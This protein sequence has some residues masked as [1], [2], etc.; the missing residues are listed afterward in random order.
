MRIKHVGSSRLSATFIHASAACEEQRE[1]E[2][3]ACN[4]GIRMHQFSMP[5]IRV[6]NYRTKRPVSNCFIQLV[7][8]KWFFPYGGSRLNSN[9]DQIT[10][11]FNT[12]ALGRMARWTLRERPLLAGNRLSTTDA[13]RTKSDIQPA[14]SLALCT[15]LAQRLVP[16]EVR[17]FVGVS[18]V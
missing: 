16:Y 2:D 11:Q 5:D 17:R 12:D 9:R 7:T 10:M 14:N 6:G 4:R 8:S 3:N 18:L 13:F 1:Q 15:L